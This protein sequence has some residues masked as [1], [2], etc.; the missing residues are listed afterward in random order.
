MSSEP[1]FD[2]DLYQAQ[3]EGNFFER[4]WHAARL[5]VVKR[6]RAGRRSA[7]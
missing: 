3:V 1:H 6:E 7:R 5:R 2:Y 4:V